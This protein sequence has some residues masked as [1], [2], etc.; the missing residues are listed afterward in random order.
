MFEAVD[1]FGEIQKSKMKN[2]TITLYNEKGNM[3][4]V[5]SNNDNWAGLPSSKPEPVIQMVV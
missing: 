2:K 4:E 5:K 3:I 1:K